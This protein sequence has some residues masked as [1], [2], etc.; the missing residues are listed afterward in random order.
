ML[1][2]D[3]LRSKGIDITETQVLD[4]VRSPDNVVDGY[5]GRKI[6]QAGLDVGRVLR[7]VYEESEGEQ[8]IVT[9]YPGRRSRYE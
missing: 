9:F 4:A 5:M 1:K 3:Y 6:A 8:V 7:V 2:F